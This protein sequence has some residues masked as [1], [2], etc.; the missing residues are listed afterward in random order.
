MERKVSVLASILLLLLLASTADAAIVEETFTIEERTFRIACGEQ[1]KAVVNG[2][3][4]GPALEA[5]EGD[6]VI[7]HV[8]N[9]STYNMTIHWHGVFQLYTNWIDGPAYVTQCP[10]RPGTSYTNRFNVTGQEGT[11][12]W[13]AHFSALRE[14]VYGPIII[15]P[16][17]G[18]NY[19]FPKPYR[20]V[21]I[22]IGEWFGANIVEL[23]EQLITSGGGSTLSD[24]RTINGAPGPLYPCSEDDVF[25]MTVV[26]GKTYLL[27]MVN[28]GLDDHVFFKLA[29]HTFTV[30]AVD[31][32]YT[33]PYRTDVI[34]LSQGQSADV[35]FSA[36]QRVGSYYMGA[37]AYSPTVA[38]QFQNGTTTAIVD[39]RVANSTN[40]S[41]T[42]MMPVF[43]DFRDTPIAHRFWSNLTSLTTRSNPHWSP[44]PRRVTERMFITVGL[45][46]EPCGGNNTCA[47]PLGSQYRFSSNLNNV[48]FLNPTSI[49]MLEAYYRN[50]SGIFTDDFPDTPPVVFNYTDPR[51]GIQFPNTSLGPSAPLV[52]LE[53]KATRVK[54]LK[55]GAVVNIVLQNTALLAAENHPMHFHGF[56]FYVLAQGFGNHDPIRDIFKYNLINPQ[57]RNT[58]A[59]PIGGWAVIRFRAI[60]PGMWFVHC[61]RE[62][63]I[64]WGLAMAILIENGPTP[65]T[66]LPPPPPDY[67]RC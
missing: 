44:V 12:F 34:V 26:R 9:N 43:P 59:V 1:V 5:R 8:I 3:L 50:I 57:E 33:R 11:L 37:R 46:L 67:P 29:G 27:R 16:R 52:V 20:E 51:L 31:A 60:N 48:S 21:P 30:V 35:L 23:E 24:A 42:P 36:N 10:I 15:R 4:P 61:H 39:Y 54:R 41:T 47:N 14:T 38:L 65:A 62:T 53:K 22:L 6:T 49:S 17:I 56:D 28:A 66:S 13:H 58:I 32:R 18:R 2:S 64:P 55:Y 40:N 19:P 7:V 25:R 63:H 45:G